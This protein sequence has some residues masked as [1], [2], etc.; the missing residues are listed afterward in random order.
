MTY[1]TPVERVGTLGREHDAVRPQR[2]AGPEYGTHIA[3]VGEALEHDD[4]PGKGEQLVHPKGTGPFRAGQV[5]TGHVDARDRAQHL[6]RCVVDGNVSL[7]QLWQ[8][9]QQALEVPRVH[10]DRDQ[11]DA[12]REG[13]AEHV[14]ALE[15]D[16]G[17]LGIETVF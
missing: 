16:E 7:A 6:P 12:R 4:A 14:E 13:K 11:L 5:A 9:L 10:K 15:D 2:N 3:H 1:G 17:V 8:Q